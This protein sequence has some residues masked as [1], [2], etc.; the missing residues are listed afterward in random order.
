MTPA[1]AYDEAAECLRES[2]AVNLAAQVKKY[3]AYQPSDH[4]R[5]VASIIATFQP[6]LFTRLSGCGLPSRRPVFVFGLPR[7]GTTLIEQVLS[8]HSQVHGAGELLLGRRD[9]EAIPGLLDQPG[10][11]PIACLGDPRI[12]PVLHQIAER[13]DA[14]LAELSGQAQRVVDKMPDNYMYLGLLA[15]LFPNASFIHCRD[16][17]TSRFPAG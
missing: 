11:L 13:H 4:E 15:I 1:S 5:F 3:Q 7:S 2:N 10:E 12:G 6:E 17:A 8:S 14:R 16:F 9:F